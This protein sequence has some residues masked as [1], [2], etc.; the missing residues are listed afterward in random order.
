MSQDEAANV[1][2]VS[3]SAIQSWEI[4]RRTPPKRTLD[5]VRRVIRGTTTRYRPDYLESP[6]VQPQLVEIGRTAAIEHVDQASGRVLLRIT[7]LIEASPP[8][9][10]DVRRE[11]QPPSS[12]P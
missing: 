10:I 1:L 12:L 2:G 9:Q 7:Y 11:E 5:R 4:G 8:I 6:R 3:R